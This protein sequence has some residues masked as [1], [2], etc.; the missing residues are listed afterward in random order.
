VLGREPRNPDF[1]EPGM[2]LPFGRCF[3]YNYRDP[4]P[5][6]DARIMCEED[7][8]ENNQAFNYLLIDGEIDGL[9]ISNFKRDA[10]RECA[11]QLYTAVISSQKNCTCII[12]G[13]L[14][15]N[16][17]MSKSLSKDI[18]MTAA[19]LSSPHP[20]YTYTVELALKA[21]QVYTLFGGDFETLSM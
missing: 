7:Y 21:K 9:E 6:N 19:K 20:K 2:P 17:I 16:V 10:L 12:D 4:C 3:A 1:W 18:S 14:L 15:D 8:V 13:L 11:P 5:D